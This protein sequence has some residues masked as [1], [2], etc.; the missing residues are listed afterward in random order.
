[1]LTPLAANVLKISSEKYSG[2]IDPEL[3]LCADFKLCSV[4]QLRTAFS[5][6]EEFGYIKKISH[7]SSRRKFKFLFCVTA[8]GRSYLEEIKVLPQSSL[9]QF[10]FNISENYGAV[11]T[12]FNIT[13][14][15]SFDFDLLGKLITQNSSAGST[16]RRELED[17]KALLQSIQN[18]QAPVEKGAL[19]KF[20][21]LMEKHSWLSSPIASFLISQFFSK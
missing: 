7:C 6:L 19:A 4:E 3:L 15:N 21:G 11:G 17:L 2:N 20:S 10:N 12:N 5:D 1:M 8:Q 9:P 18:Q 13:I 14:N 16:D